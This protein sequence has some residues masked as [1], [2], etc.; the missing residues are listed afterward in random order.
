MREIPHGVHVRNSPD[1]RDTR[2]SSVRFEYGLTGWNRWPDGSV[3]GHLCRRIVAP[4]D[5]KNNNNSSRWESLLQT[6]I[7]EPPIDWIEGREQKIRD[8]DGKIYILIG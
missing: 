5:P 4:K 8:I 3:S 6:T 7:V 1:R 2:S